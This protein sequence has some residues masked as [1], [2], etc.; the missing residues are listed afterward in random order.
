M[1]TS[2]TKIIAGLGILS[3][4]ILSSCG[5]SP[6]KTIVGKWKVTGPAKSVMGNREVLMSLD[7]DKKLTLEVNM[8]AGDS[9]THQGTYEIANEGKTLVVYREGKKDRRNEAEIVSLTS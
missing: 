4:T 6:E 3:I 8:G 5:S 1:L 2:A 7:Q 9:D